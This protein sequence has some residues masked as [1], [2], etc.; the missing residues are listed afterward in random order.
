MNHKNQFEYL[1]LEEVSYDFKQLKE[2]TDKNEEKRVE[3]I[4][5]FGNEEEKE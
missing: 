2:R 4:Q 3:V 5:I 1:Y